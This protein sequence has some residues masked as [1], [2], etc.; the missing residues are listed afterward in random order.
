MSPVPFSDI[1]KSSSDLLSKD[2]P[3]GATKLEVNTTASNGTKFT[4]SGVQDHKSSAISADFKSKYPYK[5]SGL[6]LTESWTT[7]NVLSLEAEQSDTLVKGMKL[8]LLTSLLPASGQRSAKFFA[9][10]KNANLLT[11][12]NVDLLKGPIITEDIVVASDG[13]LVGGEVAYDVAGA[14]VTR[15]NAALGYVGP[16]Y[17]VALHA[18]NAFGSFTASYFH[19]VRSDVEVGA[20]AHW[21]RSS[22]SSVSIEAGSKWVLDRDSF[23]KAKVNSAGH[24]GLGYSQI[25]RPGVKLGLGATLDTTRL[26]ADVH[27]VGMSLAFDF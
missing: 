5:P 2:Y 1:G 20:K 9:E 23:I 21:N 12:G 6:V 26:Q 14:K 19:K 27:K 13:F 25:L 17:A 3:I 15:Y 18:T 22:D 4:V 10:Y 24:L 16:D 7:G 8:T 11:R